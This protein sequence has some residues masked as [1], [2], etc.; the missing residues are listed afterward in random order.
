MRS[1][2]VAFAFVVFAGLTP[3]KIA[4]CAS[5]SPP[6]P[7]VRAERK[8]EQCEL[9]PVKVGGTKPAHQCGNIFLAGQPAKDDLAK[10]KARG[11]RTVIN[12]RMP[13]ETDWDE[14]AAVEALGMKYIS[15][16]FGG[17]DTLTV[18]KMHSALRALRT[19][20]FSDQSNGDALE[21]RKHNAKVLLHCA[22]SNRVGAI[23]YAHR[24]LHEGLEPKAALQEAKAAGLR[25]MGY[26]EPV[27][28][29]I[30][31]A[32]REKL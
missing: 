28:K 20:R 2:T 16:P 9:T 22:S 24:I 12:L 30:E 18:K 31:R 21:K 25:T 1:T 23:W 6:T 8:A 26:L 29:Y 3:W 5:P 17:P 13:D 15:V 32:K 19:G 10:W 27:E 14:R 7:S 4:H 11:V